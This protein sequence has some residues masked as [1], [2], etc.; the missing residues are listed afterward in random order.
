MSKCF[1]TNINQVTNLPDPCEGRTTYTSC[2]FHSAALTY[3]G[4]PANSSQEAINNALLLSLIDAR[5]R[6]ALAEQQ[7]IALQTSIV[8]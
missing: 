2:V 1:T 5:Q 6:L 8:M 4:L 7:I 3:L